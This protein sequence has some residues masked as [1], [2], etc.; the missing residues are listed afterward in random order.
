MPEAGGSDTGPFSLR[1]FLAGVLRLR[2]EAW[3]NAARQG[4]AAPAAAPAPPPPIAVAGS[5]PNWLRVLDARALLQVVSAH[6][7]IAEIFRVSRLSRPVFERD[8]LHALYRYAEFVQLLPASEAHHHAHAGGLLAHTVEMLL[9]AMT[10]RNGRLLP[11]GAQIEAIDAQRDDWTL[12][13]FYSAL[14]H[15]VGKA[16]TDLRVTWRARNLD[17][18]RWMPLAGSLVELAQGRAQAEY[19]V[20]FTAR[21]ERDYGAHSR[22][23]IYLLQHIASPEALQ[24]LARQPT[25][26]EALRIYLSGQDKDSLL[27]QIIR[28]ADKASV[29]RSLSSGSRARFAT[30][31]A[32][33]LID[34]L[35]G[36]L[37]A[38]LRDGAAMPLNRSGA[39]GWIHDGSLWLVAKRTADATRAWILKHESDEAVPGETKNDRLFDTW[40]EYGVIVPNPATGQA[41][42]YVTVHGG[43]GEAGD[44][45]A[46]TQ[47][48]TEAQSGDNPEA[49]K[50]DVYTHSL[51]MLRF[52]L[53]KLYD[54]PRLYPPPMSGSI[55]V[56]DKRKAGEATSQEDQADEASNEGAKPKVEAK[57]SRKASE[58]APNRDAAVAKDKPMAPMIAAPT[59]NKPKPAPTSQ[60]SRPVRQPEPEP[61]VGA[62]A[63]PSVNQ[64]AIADDDADY[65][66]DEADSASLAGLDPERERRQLHQIAKQA[67][68]MRSKTQPAPSTVQQQT[69][70][71]RTAPVHEAG[72]PSGLLLQPVG[73]SHR[74]LKQSV[75]EITARSA[76]GAPGTS[77]PDGEANPFKPVL[78][79]PKLPKLPGSDKRKDQADREAQASPVALAF[80]AW[81]KQ[82]LTSRDIKYNETGAH[83]HFVEHGMALVSPLIFKLYAATQVS[84]SEIAEHA[85]HVQREVIKAGW[86]MVGPG[87]VNIL[88]YRV[89]GRAGAV[90]G[91]LA[92]VVLTEPG[93]FVQP[94]PPTNPALALDN[95]GEASNS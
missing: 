18:V 59:F 78:L 54:D 10:W 65:F 34:L 66:L 75:P 90:A 26:F 68:K 55:E 89:L 81:L 14:L 13:V 69:A 45:E 7:A 53:D 84:E 6:K 47:A 74:L 61:E 22:T 49:L 80:I 86:H 29:Q 3:R 8:C 43:G 60:P 36:A 17:A 83:V 41:I 79:E 46:K 32:V 21:V 93:R 38:M 35:M 12:V 56:H 64:A 63:K 16:L 27:A 5:Q 71:A 40:Q 87:K 72:N 23:A 62:K 33:P 67:A 52:R 9:A 39:A 30:A 24:T 73:G 51:T 4:R 37:K 92:A 94:V 70:P 58:A 2:P 25:A 77:S 1:V 20:E 31:R 42:W 57:P 50:Q 19:L 28:E 44:V 11:E 82:A 95:Q 85:M 15:D 76:P 88:R 48:Q 91:R